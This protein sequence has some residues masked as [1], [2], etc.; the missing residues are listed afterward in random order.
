MNATVWNEQIYAGFLN[1]LSQVKV[2]NAQSELEPV[3]NITVGLPDKE[4]NEDTL[5]AITIQNYDVQRAIVN[6]MGKR[7]TYE[8]YDTEKG[9]VEY[10]PQPKKF[11]LYYQIDFWAEYQEDI[12]NMM[13][14]WE[15][16]SPDKGGA[17]SVLNFDGEEVT[18]SCS[19]IGITALNGTDT[20][21][22]LLR[23]TISYR[24]SAINDM[25]EPEVHKY[26]QSVD[27]EAKPLSEIKEDSDG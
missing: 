6:Q 10:T 8:N 14:T 15:A 7:P 24:V 11:W 3:A 22:R 23:R 17:L 19:Q 9:T 4:L 26:I 16:V 12:D 21:G 18:V 20:R 27:I 5:P 13:L 2:R 1:L 25:V